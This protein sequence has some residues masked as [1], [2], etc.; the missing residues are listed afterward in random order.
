M[1]Q[2]GRKDIVNRLVQL[3]RSENR[4]TQHW[5]LKALGNVTVDGV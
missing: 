3:T 2:V 5:A 4:T 1:R